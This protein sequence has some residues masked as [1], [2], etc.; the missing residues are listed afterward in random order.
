VRILFLVQH[1]AAAG[2]LRQLSTIAPELERRGHEVSL[3]GL[4]EV[5][6]E[7]RAVWPGDAQALGAARAAALPGAAWRLRRRVRRER[8]DVLYAFHGNVARFLAWLATRG[9]T[10][11]L[12]WG[13]QGAGRSYGWRSGIR[14]ALPYL[15]SRAVSPT[16][17]LLVANSERARMRRASE[18]F[19]CRRMITVAPGFDASTFRPDA[20][21]RKRVREEWGIGDAPLVGIVGRI[22]P[23]NK[24]HADFLHAAA[25]VAR[26]RP[27]VRFV[28]V[29][30][31]PRSRLER[32]GAE[33]LG[34]KLLWAGFRADMPAVY[35]AL[36]LLCTAS[37][38][39][40]APNV[41]G[42]AM[43][44]GVP[45]VVTDAGDSA[46]LLGGTGLV[47]PR[48][49]PAALGAAILE[50][51]E[52]DVDRAAIRAAIADRFT[53]ERCGDELEAALVAAAGSS[54]RQ[55]SPGGGA[56]RAASPP[57]A[58]SRP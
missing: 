21:A 47:V 15:A 4:H 22:D 39:E 37:L 55:S 52:R 13:V 51:L 46:K 18:G 58:R 31:G 2:A 33:L 42:E 20:A 27:D 56:P 36:D 57:H 29:G 32:L 11:T 17:P 44:T 34:D 3:A 23:V 54:R 16:V 28:V 12:V 14:R 6:A 9:T 26:R 10:T 5:E 48:K 49:D 30:H 35:N 1:L 7:W 25:R 45:C 53:I 38:N 41:V 40:G 43:L 19:R 8:P 50:L 24:R